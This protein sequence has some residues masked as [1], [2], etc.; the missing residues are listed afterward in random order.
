M[1]KLLEPQVREQQTPVSTPSAYP[2]QT[3]T[4]PPYK[5]SETLGESESSLHM[6]S[7]PTQLMACQGQDT[8]G[9]TVEKTE[10]RTSQA[11]ISSPSTVPVPPPALSEPQARQ[12]PM[13]SRPPASKPPAY[14][15]VTQPRVPYKHSETLQEKTIPAL[16]SDLPINL[17]SSTMVSGPMTPSLS[18]VSRL[19]EIVWCLLKS[20]IVARI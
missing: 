3:Q 7:A 16:R 6:L 18:I 1:P 14:P 2:K 8:Q 17:V 12:Q 15:Q 11:L 10:R 4:Q 5:H 20:S 9:H 19:L 13:V